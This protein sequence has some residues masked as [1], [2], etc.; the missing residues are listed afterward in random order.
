MIHRL[1]QTCNHVAGLLFRVE[2]ANKLGVTA[3]TSST[4]AWNV[5]SMD[6]KLQPSLLREMEFVKS[7][8]GKEGIIFLK[9]EIEI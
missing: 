1:G 2:A 7:T 3:S 5:P 6:R 9:L 4:C 8:H